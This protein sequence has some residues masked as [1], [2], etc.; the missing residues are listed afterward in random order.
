MKG[1]RGFAV[2]LLLAMAVVLIACGGDSDEEQGSGAADQPAGSPAATTQQATVRRGGTLISTIS[3]NPSGFDPRTFPGVSESIVTGNVFDSLVKMDENVVPQPFLAERIEQPDERTYLFVLRKGVKFH[4]GTD[5]N[6]E[7]VTFHLDRLRENRTTINY[8]ELQNIASTEVVDTY[9]AKVTLKEPDA[10]FLALMSARPGLIPSPTAVKTMGED[11]FKLKPVGTGPFKFVEFKNDQYV[12]LERNPEYW[13]MGADGKALPYLDKVEIRVMTEPSVQMTAIQVGDIH[14]ASA[15]RDQDI[16]VLKKDSNV[17]ILEAAGPAHS[18]MWITTT[19]APLDNKALRQAIAYAVDREEINRAIYEGGATIANGPMPPPFSW[20]REESFVPFAHD[21]AKAKAKLA[22]GGQPNG[23]EFTAW[24]GAGS[25]QTQQLAEL[26]QA[27]LAKAGITMN[28][29]L[30]DFNGVIRPK[31]TAGEGQAYVYSSSCAYIDP[32]N[33]T[34]FFLP[35]NSTNFSKYENPRVTTLL[36][37][38]LRSTNR[39]ERGRIYKEAQRLITDDAPIV[40]FVYPVTRTITA[41]KVQGA[42]VGSKATAGYS[43]FWLEN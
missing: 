7:A 11:A 10:S 20:A 28:I 37:E 13:R 36:D 43:E 40:F 41:K 33:C 31:M 16:P 23:F 22:E 9:T 5:L 32:A 21:P 27:Q 6:A 18:S 17:A 14:I 29:E 2:A 34:R 19:R 24:F 25:S 4:D 38:G 12:M 35:G 30:A 1:T 3:G 39:E 15:I 8:V 42:F 26:L